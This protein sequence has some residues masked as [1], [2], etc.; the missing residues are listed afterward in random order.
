VP[1][2]GLVDPDYQLRL[3]VAAD[4]ADGPVYMLSL[5][6]FRPGSGQVFGRESGRDPDSRYV[7]TPLLAAVGASLC[8]VADVVAGSGG[9]NRVGVI[10]Y[11]TRRAFGALGDRSDTKDW[12]ATKER[13]AERVIMLGLVPVAGLPVEHSQRV[14]L[15]VWHGPTPPPMAAGPATEFDVEGTYIGDGRQWSGARYT[16]LDPGIALPLDPARFGYLA[17][18]VE[19]VIERW[20]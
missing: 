14:L 16:P 12:I 20:I 7:P 15:E 18:L 17:V 2:Y 9:W 5:A 10:R 13:R 1:S 3:R 6:R 19:P 8:L 4:S 11:P